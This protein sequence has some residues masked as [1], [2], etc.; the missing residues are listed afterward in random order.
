MF[1]KIARY[2]KKEGEQYAPC[3]HNT[4]GIPDSMVMAS[5]SDIPVV[6]MA[7]N[8]ASSDE[9]LIGEVLAII[10]CMN[11]QG[12][13]VSKHWISEKLNFKSR[14]ADDIIAELKREGKINEMVCIRNAHKHGS[15]YKLAGHKWK[16]IMQ[17]AHARLRKD[18]RAARAAN[19]ESFNSPKKG[20]QHSEVPFSEISNETG[21]V[22]ENK[23]ESL[24]ESNGFSKLKRESKKS[25]SPKRHYDDGTPGDGISGTCYS[26]NG[27]FARLTNPDF[28]Y[29]YGLMEELISVSRNGLL[30]PSVARSAA[31]RIDSGLISP[32]TVA[33]VKNI[34]I[35]KS[36]CYD[37]RDIILNFEQILKENT[38]KLHTDE[39]WLIEQN[40]NA[41]IDGTDSTKFNK[42]VTAA[43]E[44]FTPTYNADP[45][46]INTSFE[47]LLKLFNAPYIPN[48]AKLVAAYSCRVPTELLKRLLNEFKQSIYK[49]IAGNKTTYNFL[50]NKLK[51]TF[52][53]WDEIDAFKQ[54]MLEDIKCT[55]YV[56]KLSN[57]KLDTYYRQIHFPYKVYANGCEQFAGVS[58]G[59]DTQVSE[60]AC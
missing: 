52:I 3:V 13:F 41:A 2:Q 27:C 36:Y 49:S 39:L 26:A 20:A 24:A 9:R 48:Y 12:K 45:K 51:I 19:K 53:D 33:K 5:L 10:G 38:E 60:N 43:I 23:E 29:E 25:N 17:L 21:V 57:N 22:E 30:C 40:I 59:H 35:E 34:I 44:L 8:Y 15:Y 54:A 18:I 46:Y 16:R 31:R 28:T 4:F 1:W 32:E 56:N 47:K 50:K 11:K 42:D 14:K 58:V 55:L 7:Y 37:I 6:E